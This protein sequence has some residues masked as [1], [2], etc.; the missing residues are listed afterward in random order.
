MWNWVRSGSLLIYVVVDNQ[1][2]KLKV[3]RTTHLNR[4]IDIYAEEYKFK[5]NIS[6]KY[7]PFVVASVR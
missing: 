1:T 5:K 6:A 2:E 4:D 3:T 7:W